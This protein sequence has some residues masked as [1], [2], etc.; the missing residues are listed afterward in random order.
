M[1]PATD[2]INVRILIDQS[3]VEVFVN[4]G[5]YVF[6]D[7]VFPK[8]AEG[9]VELFAAKGKANFSDI[10]VKQVKKSIH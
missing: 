7:Q 10:S 2:K 4:D 8:H 3:I 9:A 5:E 6:T 1:N